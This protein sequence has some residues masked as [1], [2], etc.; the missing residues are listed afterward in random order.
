MRFSCLKATLLSL[1]DCLTGGFVR[2][3]RGVGLP[4]GGE[5]KRRWLGSSRLGGQ[6]VQ[7]A[8]QD[9][10]GPEA[11]TLGISQVEQ[12][13]I[14]VEKN[15]ARFSRCSSVDMNLTSIHEDASSIP[16]LSQWVKD[17]VLP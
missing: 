13:Y 6:H 2:N 5:G 1:A 14:H 15:S 17:P 9:E 8:S 7:G 11:L 12:D 4:L 3:G 10:S 16:G